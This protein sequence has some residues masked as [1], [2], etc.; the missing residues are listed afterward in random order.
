MQTHCKHRQKEGTKQRKNLCF[1]VFKKLQG[2]FFTVELNE[3]RVQPTSTEVRFSRSLF[4]QNPLIS[5][6]HPRQEFLHVCFISA[7]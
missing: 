3:N 6:L 7:R 1:F 4:K 5:L 2:D